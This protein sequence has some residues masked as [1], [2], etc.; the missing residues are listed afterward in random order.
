MHEVP[1]AMQRFAELS[2]QIQADEFDGYLYGKRSHL[3]L[4]RLYQP[5]AAL[6]DAKQMVT[7][8]PDLAESH[9][10]LSEVHMVCS[11][12]LEPDP[13]ICT[14]CVPAEAVK[15]LTEA[16]RLEPSNKKVIAAFRGVVPIRALQNEYRY[17]G[18]EAWVR[19][20]NRYP[21]QDEETTAA[22]LQ[23]LLLWK[24]AMPCW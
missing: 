21:K 23:A 19:A 9:V 7:R 5:Q 11:R 6:A 13:E 3:L 15:S 17:G 10:L 8:L 2:E 12:L 14:L 24:S 16:L 18:V 1:L 20:H 4:H 22:I